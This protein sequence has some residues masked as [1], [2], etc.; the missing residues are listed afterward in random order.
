MM[1]RKQHEALADYLAANVFFDEEGQEV[2]PDSADVNGFSL[3]LERYT[4]GLAIEQ[5]AVEHLVEN[6]EK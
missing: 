2:L 6:W 1:N 5:A 3:F 4:E